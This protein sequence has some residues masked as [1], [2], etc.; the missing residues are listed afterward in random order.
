M[1]YIQSAYCQRAQ[2]APIDYFSDEASPNTTF[3]HNAFPKEHEWRSSELRECRVWCYESILLLMTNPYMR[4]KEYRRVDLVI[5][6]STL[7][8]WSVKIR[9]VL[10]DPYQEAF[11]L[12]KRL[13]S[14][15][16]SSS[17]TG[18]S[19]EAQTNLKCLP[20]LKDQLTL[21]RSTKFVPCLDDVFFRRQFPVL[22][23]IVFLFLQ[24]SCTLWRMVSPLRLWAR[25]WIYYQDDPL[26]RLIIILSLRNTL[27][28]QLLHWTSLSP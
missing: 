18:K 13:A 17:R 11:T 21:V 8:G 14:M 4:K 15:V 9:Q 28:P 23:S 7:R 12:Q 3:L 1:T 16:C 27:S 5:T 26:Y 19:N 20:S 2:A 22:F 6:V 10:A 24:P 25:P